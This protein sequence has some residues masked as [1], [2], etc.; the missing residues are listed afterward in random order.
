MR[1]PNLLSQG[2]PCHVRVFL[3][4]FK[5]IALSFDRQYINTGQ[6]KLNGEI[7]QRDTL[8]LESE[9]LF[10]MVLDGERLNSGQ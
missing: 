4:D 1:G 10:D 5:Q 6:Y 7:V 2:H 8:L 9:D 3:P